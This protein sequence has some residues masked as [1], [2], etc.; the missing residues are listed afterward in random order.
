MTPQE[1]YEY[2]SRWMQKG[3]YAVAVDSDH[4]WQGKRW[5]SCNLERHQ[6]SF[7]SY[8]DHYEHTFYFEHEEA[9]SRFE[10]EYLK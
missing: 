6:W 1:I 2:K 3:G 9:A 10:K 4:D 7:S 8:T 5:C